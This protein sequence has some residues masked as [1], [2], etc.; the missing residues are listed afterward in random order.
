MTHYFDA[1]ET[2][3]PGQRE[4]ELFA[5]L[6]RHVAHAKSHAPA[7]REVL[8][9]IDPR[10]VTSRNALARLPLTRKGDLVERQQAAPPFGGFAAAGWGE[11]LR[12]FASPGPIYEPQG[13]NADYW[14]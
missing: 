9:A 12:V 13:T 3:D 6:R 8:A 2:R 11:A 10:E 4:R 1:L 5:Q 7:Y 14:R